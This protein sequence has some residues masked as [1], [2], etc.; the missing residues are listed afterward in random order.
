[1][2]CAFVSLLLIFF[3][4]KKRI[5]IVLFLSFWVNEW[6][7]VVYCVFCMVLMMAIEAF[8]IYG[9]IVHYPIHHKNNIIFLPLLL[10]FA[11]ITCVYFKSWFIWSGVWVR[12]YCTSVYWWSI[13][14]RLFVGSFYVLVA[15]SREFSFR[16]SFRF[17]FF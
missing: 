9:L 6:K 5:N 12:L 17:L 4:R 1:M 16:F 8:D 10:T 11:V 14:A 3:K 13:S 15:L 2:V 7:C